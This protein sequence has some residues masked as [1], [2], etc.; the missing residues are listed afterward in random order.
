MVRRPY[1]VSEE[2][3][4]VWELQSKQSHIVLLTLNC[5][6]DESNHTLFFSLFISVNAYSN[7][8]T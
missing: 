6:I 1:I 8:I 4:I 2:I 7:I 3:I 5:V